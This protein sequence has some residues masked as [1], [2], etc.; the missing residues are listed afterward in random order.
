M[1]R[2]R[3]VRWEEALGLDS[4]K[5]KQ[6]SLGLWPV[7]G[8]RRTG[9]QRAVRGKP[10]VAAVAAG[11]RFIELKAP[12][13]SGGPLEWEAVVE[14]LAADGARITLRLRDSSAALPG[15]IAALRGRP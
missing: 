13:G 15:L 1:A 11:A 8:G 3:E 5:L 14:V 9:P 6:V 4:H 12:V 2:Y 10:S 7:Q